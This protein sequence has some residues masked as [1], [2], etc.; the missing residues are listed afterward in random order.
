MRKL[1]LRRVVRSGYVNFKRNG[2]VSFASIVV[3]TVTLSVIAAIF[4]VQ[5]IL[6]KSLTEVKER[7]DI[8]VTF[9]TTASEE[10]ILAVKSTIE[11]VP[12][13]ASVTYETASERLAA[14]RLNH[15]NDALTLQALSELGDTNPLGAV[16]KI[17]ARDTNQYESIAKLFDAD[18]VLVKNSISIIEKVSFNQ[19]RAIIDALNDTIANVDKLSALVTLVL[20]L[21]SVIV[22]FNTIRLTIHFAR[23]EIGIMRLVG[24]EKS[25]VRGPF[26]VE[27]MLYGV[28]ATIL[29]LVLCV[30]ITYWFGKNMTG[31]LG[32]NLFSFFWSK[33][34]VLSLILLGSGIG[35]G[36]ISSILATRKYLNK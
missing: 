14:F 30:P 36:V 21:L 27:G 26:L 31:F 24:A 17:K 20:I 4:F 23:E 29:T 12:E 11:Q 32:I 19:N 25:Y 16:L 15:Q 8:T 18:S 28:Y 35:L 33:I 5:A 10:S 2:I 6:S 3:M 1:H 22:T 7:V 34:L 9:V 13:V